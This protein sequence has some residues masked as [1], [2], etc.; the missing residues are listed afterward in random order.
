MTAARLAALALVSAVAALA[1]PAPRAE[2]HLFNATLSRQ[3]TYQL[4]HSHCAPGTFW[5]CGSVFSGPS[6]PTT[7]PGHP[8]QRQCYVAFW[9][10]SAWLSTRINKFSVHVG[11]YGGIAYWSSTY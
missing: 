5:Y 7:V 3:E 2:A 4:G 6:C 8:H 11:H 1:A 9:N 10:T